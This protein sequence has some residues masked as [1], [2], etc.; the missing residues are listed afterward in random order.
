MLRKAFWIILL[1]TLITLLGAFF[2]TKDFTFVC[3]NTLIS[4]LE[5]VP[6]QHAWEKLWAGLSCIFQ[7]VGCVFTQFRHIF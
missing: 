1:I 7:N 4:C 3:T 5:K 6:Q 2:S